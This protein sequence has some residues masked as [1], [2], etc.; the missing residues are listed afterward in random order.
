MIFLIENPKVIVP[1]VIPID[2][3]GDTHVEGQREL[4][5]DVSQG[6]IG[7]DAPQEEIDVNVP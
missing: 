1:T 4:G 2:D 3:V 6:E 5:D 7:S